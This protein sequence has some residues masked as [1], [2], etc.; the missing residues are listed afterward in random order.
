MH[1]A[2]LIYIMNPYLH[3]VVVSK[4]DGY[5]AKTIHSIYNSIVTSKAYVESSKKNR[6]EIINLDSSATIN[7]IDGDVVQAGR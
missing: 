5:D 4:I 7:Y 2:I 3:S 6:I 1:L